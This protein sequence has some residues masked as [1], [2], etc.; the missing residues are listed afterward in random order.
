VNTGVPLPNQGAGTSLPTLAARA[1]DRSMCS[2]RA[3][4][5]GTR[6]SGSEGGGEETTGRK[7]GIGASPP[8]LRVAGRYAGLRLVFEAGADYAGLVEVRV[9]ESSRR[10]LHGLLART[11]RAGR[12]TRNPGTGTLDER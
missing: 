11:L 3:G 9:S 7:A 2:W 10:G 5:G 1:G 12:P 6:K 4:C 8:T